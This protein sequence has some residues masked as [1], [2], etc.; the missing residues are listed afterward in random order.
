MS[1]V[2]FGMVL[3]ASAA[4]FLTP[5]ALAAKK[6]ESDLE[7]ALQQVEEV[8]EFQAGAETEDPRFRS[9][10]ALVSELK[11]SGKV[12]RSKYKGH[13]LSGPRA[14]GEGVHTI[15]PEQVAYKFGSRE[16]V[17]LDD[18]NNDLE[19]RLN[20]GRAPTAEDL[21]AADRLRWLAEGCLPESELVLAS[22]Q[23]RLDVLDAGDQ[24]A[25]FLEAW[26][27]RGPDGDES[28]YEALD[29]TA[30][31]PDEVFF[32]DA[33]L[34]DFAGKFGGRAAMRWSRQ[35]QHEYTQQG[36]LSYRQYRGL[37]EAVSYSLVLPPD[38]SL[39]ERLKR[40][41]YGSVG[42]GQLSLRHQIDLLVESRKGDVKPV[43]DHVESFLKEHPLPDPLWEKYDPLSDFYQA[44]QWETNLLVEREKLSTDELFEALKKRR[45]ELA[46]KIREACQAVITG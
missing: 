14:S 16:V 23:Q 43:L 45:I 34:G 41:D 29:R 31:T 6:R 26:R 38:L 27:N 13:S 4:G 19:K 30:G 22:I 39:P 20:K 18:R 3:L 25:L 11:A 35:Q 46:A 21:S 42:A 8:P 24:L 12:A 17:S 40:Y 37:I 44:I 15:L 5:A 7:K 33:M 36:F 2:R 10:R 32:Y 1:R 28:F 9:L